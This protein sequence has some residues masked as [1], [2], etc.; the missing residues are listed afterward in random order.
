MGRG[1]LARPLGP[2]GNRQRHADHRRFLRQP[3][4]HRRVVD[5]D[6]RHGGQRRRRRRRERRVLHQRQRGRRRHPDQQRL[7]PGCGRGPAAGNRL[8]LDRGRPGGGENA[9]SDLLRHDRLGPA[10]RPLQRRP[11][12]P[13]DQHRGP[14]RRVVDDDRLRLDLRGPAGRHGCTD[15]QRGQRRR[16]QRLRLRQLH[17]QQRRHPRPQ[18]RRRDRHRLRDAHRQPVQ[19]AEW[20]D[21]EP[22]HLVRQGRHRNE[23][24]H[25]R[26]ERWCRDDL[27]LGHPHPRPREL[28]MGRRGL[29]RFPRPAAHRRQRDADA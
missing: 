25:R 5:H 28:G 1:R 12:R 4:L 26:V 2:G 11:V 3:H 15:H 7:G 10:R 24:R 29:R 22:P 17:R 23:M 8:Q 14:A 20:P 19:P 13:G 27:L 9:P 6:R 16:H 18:R 21:P